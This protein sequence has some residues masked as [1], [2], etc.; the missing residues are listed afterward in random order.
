ML[1]AEGMMKDPLVKQRSLAP[2]LTGTVT[3]GITNSDMGRVGH[4]AKSAPWRILCQIC[5]YQLSLKSATYILTGNEQGNF[6]VK[7]HELKLI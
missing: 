6:S 2:P 7:I 3:K 4:R 1:V 5:L